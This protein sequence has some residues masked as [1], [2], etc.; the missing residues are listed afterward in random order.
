M[1]PIPSWRR[2]FEILDELCSERLVALALWESLRDVALWARSDPGDRI[3]LFHPPPADLWSDAGKAIPEIMESLERFR[4][5][6]RTPVDLVRDEVA[7]ACRQVYQ[8]AEDRAYLQTAAH[9]AEAAALVKSNDASLANLAARTCRRAGLPARAGPWYVRGRVLAV[10]ANDFGEKFSAFVGYGWLMY[11]LGRYD[12]A[13]RIIDKAARAA[14]NERHMRMA[15]EAEHNLL[16]ICSELKQYKAG[17]QYALNA[18][19]HYPIH[20]PLVPFLVHD[21][22]YLFVACAFYSPALNLLQQAIKTMRRPQDPVLAW[23]TMAQAAAGAHRTD[24]YHEARDTALDLLETYPEFAPATLRSL[25]YAAQLAEDWDV[26]EHVARNAAEVARARRMF[27]VERTSLELLDRVRIR[28]PGV[29]ET[30]P[31]ALN[32]IET[33]TRAC[34]IK[35]RLWSGPKRGRPPGE[36]PPA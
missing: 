35:L 8:W 14:Y 16:A 10:L 23:G 5:L 25:G 6:V 4:D 7:E 30:P 32:R 29:P 22:A 15:G 3:Y 17:E 34:R 21:V 12:R 20:H 1:P 9:F 18:L 33:I 31:P 11:S 27:E 13:R 36:S 24:L 2:D 28:E 19:D 26:A